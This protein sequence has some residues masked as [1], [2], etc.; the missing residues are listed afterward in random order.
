MSEF[1]LM[2]MVMIKE[3]LELVAL[4]QGYL[5]VKS[6]QV[7]VGLTCVMILHLMCR[8]ILSEWPKLV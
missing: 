5:Q 4:K 8:G 3:G 2:L 6:I 7:M 1:L